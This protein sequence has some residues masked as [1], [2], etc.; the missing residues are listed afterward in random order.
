MRKV[1]TATLLTGIAL[2]TIALPEAARAQSKTGTTFAQF[3]GIEP[4]ARHAALGNAGVAIQEGIDSIYY[5]AAAAGGLDGTQV[6]LTHSEWFAGISFDYVAAALPLRDWG[7]LF[8]TVMALNSGEIDVRTVSQ[9][10]GTGERYTVSD[11]AIG[12]GFGRQ[13]TQRFAAGIQFKFVGETI[14]HSSAHAVT[15]DIGTLYWLPETGLRIGASLSNLGTTAA[16]S[17]RDLAIQYDA[18]P[19][20]YGGNSALPAEQWTGDFPVPIL[21][22]IGVAWPRTFGRDHR[23]FLLADAHHPNDNT[24]SL[25]FGSEWEW[26]RTLALRAGYQSLFQED[27]E[28]GLTLGAGLSHKVGDAALRADYAWAS[29]ERLSR[30]H[31]FTVVLQF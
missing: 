25:S 8:G 14:W 11:I 26:R 4:S 6:Q 3:L 1:L 21:F 30:T 27:S 10:L 29:H 18:D 5:N 16:F 13:V 19:D 24:E 12:L 15:F 31:R 28:L 7:H 9:P 22:R 17:G 2:A 20:T 23:V